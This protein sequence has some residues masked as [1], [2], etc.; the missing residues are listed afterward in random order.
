M[1]DDEE[2]LIVMKGRRQGALLSQQFWQAQISGVVHP[3][4]E[5]RHNPRFEWSLVVLHKGPLYDCSVNWAT[6]HRPFTASERVAFM[7]GHEISAIYRKRNIAFALGS[8]SWPNLI[9]ARRAPL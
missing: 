5:I 8:A 6:V 9:R 3:A 7:S 1:L 2:H 4:C